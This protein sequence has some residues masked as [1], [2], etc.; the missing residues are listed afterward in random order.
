MTIASAPAEASL[1]DQMLRDPVDAWY[2]LLTVGAVVY[3]GRKALVGVFEEARA[4]DERGAMANKMMEETKRRERAEKREAVKQ[5]EP[6]VYRRMQAEAK[7]RAN[8][9]DG[10]KVFD[11]FKD[12]PGF[13]PKRED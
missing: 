13:G 4:Y 5:E 10:W 9:R 2:A 7:E 12:V 3:F 6:F 1:I 11:G 8:K